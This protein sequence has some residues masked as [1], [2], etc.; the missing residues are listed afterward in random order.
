MAYLHSLGIVHG[1]LSGYNVLLSSTAPG[2]S[3]GGRG[4]AARVC[5]FGLARA[6]GA[7]ESRALTRTCGTVTHAA[8]E[9]L[10]R[11]VVSKASDVYSF[12]VLLWQ[13]ACGVRPWGGMGHAAIINAVCNE[14]RELEF[15]EET[16]EGIKLL[17]RA[18]MAFEPAERPT[19]EE[20]L[21]VL[22]PL[23]AALAGPAAA[24]DS[25]DGDDDGDDA[26]AAA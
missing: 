13:M 23:E 16:P 9:T 24:L 25:C 20:V 2:A 6:L 15:G 1:D 12:G 7:N 5:D 22:A 11:G 4:F 19:F 17:A 8:P 10:S 14:R 3:H 26:S 21:E 18:A